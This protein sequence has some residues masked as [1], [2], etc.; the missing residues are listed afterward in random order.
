VVVKARAV[1]GMDGVE[2]GAFGIAE[3]VG[4]STVREAAELSGA[5]G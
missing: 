4:S 2:G 3:V 5:R 1:R